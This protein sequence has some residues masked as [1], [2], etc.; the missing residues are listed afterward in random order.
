PAFVDT[1]PA[2]PYITVDGL[3]NVPTNNGVNYASDKQYMNLPQQ[4]TSIQ[5]RHPYAAATALAG[6]NSF[7]NNNNNSDNMSWLAHFDRHLINSVELLQVA[8][9]PPYLLTSDFSS[10]A[11]IHNNHTAGRFFT[12]LPTNKTIPNEAGM[13]EWY[14]ALDLLTVKPRF[15]GVPVGGAEPGKINPNTLW[16]SSTSNRVWKAILDRQTNNTF[17]DAFV[18]TSWTNFQT[19]AKTRS[20]GT[21]GRTVTEG[22]TDRPI[23]Q[24][25]QATAPTVASQS[26]PQSIFR[27]AADTNTAGNP[28]LLNDASVHDHGKFEPLRKLWGQ[29]T[30]TSDTFLVIFTVSF[31]EV[32]DPGTGAFPKMVLGKEVFLETPGDLR[33]QFCSVIDRS[34]MTI[35]DV[36]TPTTATQP[37]R[38]PW[39][40]SLTADAEVGSNTLHMTGAINGSAANIFHNGETITV[41]VGDRIRVGFGDSTNTLATPWLAGSTPDNNDGEW[42]T[43]QSISQRLLSP[44]TTMPM[45]AATYFPGQVTLRTTTNLTRNH[46]SSSPVSNAILGYPGPQPNFSYKDN[47]AAGVVPYMMEMPK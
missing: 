29:T 16:E 35:N 32:R 43:V 21:A 9:C 1:L 26:P 18:D 8:A 42:V 37:G 7:F 41:N 4:P 28:I 24:I 23:Y 20:G 47:S 10:A 14:K 25:S 36:T 6:T 34:A 38:K 17:D 27:A 5:R 13:L 33:K 44:A 39:M 46:S 2:N 45:A 30:A 12:N 40:T 3:D 15:N 22:G 19:Y 11:D 31:F